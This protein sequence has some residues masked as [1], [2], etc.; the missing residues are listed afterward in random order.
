MIRTWNG[1]TPEVDE[2]AFVSEAAYVVGEVEIGAESSIWPC[3]V[4]RGDDGKITIGRD[5]HVQDGS[6]VHSYGPS[7]LDD[8]VNIGHSVVLH[9]KRIGHHSIIGNNATLLEDVEIGEFCLVGANAMVRQ[10]A[11]IPPYSFVAGVP[12]GIRPLSDSQREMLEKA[13]EGFAE[14]ARQYKAEGNLE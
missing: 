6:V 9:S 4:V 1:K 11:K 10:G 2:T 3:V 13:T 12:A 8:H 5:T 14:W 7:A